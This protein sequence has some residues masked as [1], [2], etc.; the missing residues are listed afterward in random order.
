MKLVACTI[1]YHPSSFIY[2]MYFFSLYAYKYI[3]LHGALRHPNEP[4]Q[5]ARLNRSNERLT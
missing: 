4:S 5:S 1:K 3:A 2:L